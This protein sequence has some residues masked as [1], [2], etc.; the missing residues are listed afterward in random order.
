MPYCCSGWET[1]TRHF[2]RMPLRPPRYSALRSPVVPTGLRNMWSWP[3]SHIT[4]LIHICPN[5]C[6]PASVW[7]YVSSLKIRK[8]QKNSLSAASPSLSLPV[9]QSTTMCLII[10]RTT[11]LPPYIS[12]SRTPEWRFL[13]SRQASFLPPRARSI[14]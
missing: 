10:A 12:A 14:M 1:F 8:R 13:T 6:V 4:H 11:S 3:V 5:W 2:Q 9:C 7:L